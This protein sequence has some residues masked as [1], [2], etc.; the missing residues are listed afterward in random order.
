MEVYN[1]E[2]Q[3]TENE[4]GN[5]LPNMK[6]DEFRRPLPVMGSR[7]GPSRDTGPN[8][9]TMEYRSN[10]LRLANLKREKEKEEIMKET[11]YNRG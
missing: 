1:T 8:R 2:E 3:Y 9:N 4:Y 6:K 5:D 7:H 10:N 11:Q